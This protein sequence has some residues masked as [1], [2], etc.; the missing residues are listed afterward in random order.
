MRG[1][2]R[3]RK[4]FLRVCSIGRCSHVFSLAARRMLIFSSA[5]LGSGIAGARIAC[6]AS[7]QTIVCIR[8]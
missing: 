4:S 2:L 6:N 3:V 7:L 5:Y 1:R 8:L